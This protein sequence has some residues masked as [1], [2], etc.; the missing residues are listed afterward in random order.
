MADAE[1]FVF[2][3]E[4]EVGQDFETFPQLRGNTVFMDAADT[5][6]K[7]CFGSER[8]K[9]HSSLKRILLELNKWVQKGGGS[10]M[11]A[12]CNKQS[13]WLH[14]ILLSPNNP[15]I[16]LPDVDCARAKD[17]E[18]GHVLVADDSVLPEIYQENA[19]DAFSA[20]RHL[21]RF[22]NNPQALSL[23]SFF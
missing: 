22:G 7:P 14:G 1:S 13:S 5:P 11:V 3:F 19:A 18:M 6:L 20:I 21:Q 16:D 4:K 2:D 15:I 17:H 8:T 9:M 10:I 23:V 12:A